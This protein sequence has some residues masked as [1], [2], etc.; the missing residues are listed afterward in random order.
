MANKEGEIR[1]AAEEIPQYVLDHGTYLF[2][3]TGNLSIPL[4]PLSFG[5]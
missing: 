3:H 2:S 4:F 1:S 5:L